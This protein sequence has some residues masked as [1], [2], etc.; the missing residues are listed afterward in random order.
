MSYIR[1]VFGIISKRIDLIF[2]NINISPS[3]TR[4]VL[5]VSCKF[6]MQTFLLTHRIENGFL[7]CFVFV[8]VPNQK[9]LNVKWNLA[10]VKKEEWKRALYLPVEALVNLPLP[11]PG[12][13]LE[14]FNSILLTISMMVDQPI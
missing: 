1:P 4:H 7:L 13:K 3:F 10:K 12:S 2:E 9:Y 6:I 14:H 5:K 8:H 11:F